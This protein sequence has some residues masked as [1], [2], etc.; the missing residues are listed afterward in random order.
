MELRTF[1]GESNSLLLKLKKC[2]E[3]AEKISLN[4]SFIQESGVKILEKDLKEALTKGKKIEIITG[5]YLDITSPQALYRLLDLKNENL[6]VK[7]F[8]NNNNISYHP[9]CYIFN[10]GDGSKEL[11]IGSSNLS[12]SALSKGVEWNYAINSEVDSN[13]IEYF[14]EQ[15]NE[16]WEK[17]SFELNDVWLRKYLNNRKVKEM[18]SEEFKIEKEENMEVELELKMSPRG[19]QI[20]ALYELNK[21]RE[22]GCKKAMIVV[23]TGLGKTYL[24]AFDSLKYEKILFIAHRTELLEQAMESYKKVH[25]D[26]KMGIFNGSQKEKEKDIL[27]AS[28]QTLSKDSY[29]NSEYFKK[30]AFDYIVVDEFHHSDSPSYRKVINY[31]SPKFLL[32]ITATPDRL[33]QGDIAAICDNNIA[34]ECEMATGINNGWLTPFEYYGV[35]DDVNYEEIPWRGGKYSLEDLESKIIIES[36]FKNILEKYRNYKKGKALGFCVSVKHAEEINKFFKK[37]KIKSEIISGSTNPTER[38]DILN[39]FRNGEVEIIFS[40]DVF[41]EGLDVPSIETVMF[42]RPTD[43]DTIFLQQ[44]GRGLRLYKNKEKLVVIDFVGNFRGVENRVSL[45]SGKRNNKNVILDP[46][47]GL[48]L[49]EGCKVN[50]DLRVIDLLREQKGRILTKEQLLKEE[51]LRVEEYLGKVPTILEMYYYSTYK[52]TEYKTK[53]KSWQE[54]LK[55]MGKLSDEEKKYQDTK[56]SEFLAE[57]EKTVMT[58]S[59]KIPIIQTFFSEEKFKN[60]VTLSELVIAFENFY[61]DEM[62]RKDLEKIEIMNKKEIENLIL[63]MPVKFLIKS[64]SQFF[65][66][67][68][69]KFILNK[70]LV[71]LIN[72]N[73]SSLN[74]ICDTLK[75]RNINY[76]HRKYMEE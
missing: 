48:V 12:V 76:F 16:V 3:K 41:N 8:E 36:K 45:L 20:P 21:V 55:I 74:N 34:F 73:P 39:R 53:F 68:E 33:D 59:Y 18:L 61:K 30:D 63:S 43:S 7:I 9:K 47:K 25:I 62:Y 14:Q 72:E 32:G 42:L 28:I 56:L 24:S 37:N 15:F 75:Y 31:F 58:K 60:E 69:N 57:L 70:D 35:Y 17:R 51:F 50:F 13:S 4:V 64:L 5:T 27:F 44:L 46:I 49:P 52:I 38:K 23:A 67:I 29:L 10:Y 11:I 2:I 65:S 6:T 54:F 22:D 26:K 40:V 19:F 71:K 1:V 66:F